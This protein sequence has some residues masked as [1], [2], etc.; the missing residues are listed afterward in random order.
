MLL[1]K[2]K[3]EDGIR[4]FHNDIDVD[5]LDYN[6]QGLD[7]LYRE[8]ERHFWF[9]AR[10]E[11]IFQQ[12]RAV[13]GYS[14]KIIE[15]GAGTGNVSRY[16]QAKG[17][18]NI[19]VGEMH[20]NGLKYAKSSYGIDECY[21]FDLLRTPFEDEFEGVCIFD[22]LEHIEDDSLALENIHKMLKNN[23]QIV[24]TVPAHKWLWN[25][26]DVIAGHKRRYTKKELVLKLQN[27][28][29]SIEITKYFFI[30][31]VPF[32]WLRTLLNKDR[33]NNVNP[34]E[35]ASDFSMNPMINKTLLL[36]SRIENK[37]N[38]FLPNWFGGSLLIIARKNDTI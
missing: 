23:G 13:I 12:M 18:S 8:E 14:S 36:I 5:H 25:R 3:E 35:Y 20:S 6:S 29:F 30:T 22:V 34:E 10:K 17:Y 1:E 24:L 27:A 4:I 15:I 33:K 9:I 31:I 19:A 16:L 11:Y 32:L 26:D 28:G 37:L 38:K 21:Q 2:Y 7:N